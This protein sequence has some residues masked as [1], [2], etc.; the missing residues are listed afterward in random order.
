MR[1]SRMRTQTKIAYHQGGVYSLQNPS[2]HLWN[3]TSFSALIRVTQPP[4]RM[5]E[6]AH[7]RKNAV[8]A[9]LPDSADSRKRTRGDSESLR[10]EFGLAR[11]EDGVG[12][13][14]APACGSMP[15]IPPNTSVVLKQLRRRP[16]CRGIGYAQDNHDGAAC[17]SIAARFDS[18]AALR[19]LPPGRGRAWHRATRRR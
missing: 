11:L 5:E 6:E 1:S 7:G 15:T 10:R 3:A 8:K 2:C 12:L 18:P 17:G 16:Q 13:E 9:S 4:T 14:A 19:S